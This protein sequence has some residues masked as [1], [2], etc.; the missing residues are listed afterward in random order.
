VKQVARTPVLGV[1]GSSLRNAADLNDGGLRYPATNSS[2]EVTDLLP[3]IILEGEYKPC[4]ECAGP[5]K[6]QLVMVGRK[7]GV[8]VTKASTGELIGY[9]H[10]MNCRDAW[11]ERGSAEAGAVCLPLRLFLIYSGGVTNRGKRVATVSAVLTVG[12]WRWTEPTVNRRT[13]DRGYQLRLVILE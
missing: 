11:V 5:D 4:M 8:K 2:S 1:R 7:L 10:L 6:P 9:L 12:F 13:I 3:S